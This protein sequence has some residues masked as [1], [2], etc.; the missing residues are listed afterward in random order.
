MRALTHLRSE[1]GSMSIVTLFTLAM[2]IVGSI[3]LFYF[4][5]AYIE[6]RQSQN[7][8]DAASLAAAQE[9]RDKF[10]QEMKRK[11]GETIGD[12][13][14]ELDSAYNAI[15][16]VETRP[17][18]DDF[19]K[20][21]IGDHL[22]TEELKQKLAAGTFDND[23]D[24]LLV[25][26]EPYFQSKFTAQANGDLL[27]DAFNQNAAAIRAAAEYAIALNRG[28]P[29]GKITF[30]DEQKPKLLLEATRTVRIDTVGVD[31][32]INSVAS[33][34]VSSASFDIDVSG[35]TPREIQW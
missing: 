17:P 33:A 3:F 10:E 14:T 2:V 25:V 29:T 1:K 23:E 24:W 9:L 35:K 20:T 34:G 8:A 6:K 22:R 15:V 30:P 5:T 16:P 21:Y 28:K 11:T 27:Y 26:K 32:E 18:Y 12:F 13:M 7:I 31:K 19:K 4:F